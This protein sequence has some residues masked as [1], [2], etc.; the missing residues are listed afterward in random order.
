MTY[1]GRV[2]RQAFVDK[3]RRQPMKQKASLSDKTFTVSYQRSLLHF[4]IYFL[5]RLLLA[6]EKT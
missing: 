5:A 6:V 1:D 3:A 4:L 2:E